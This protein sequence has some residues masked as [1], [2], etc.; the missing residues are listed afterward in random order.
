MELLNWKYCQDNS[1]K[2]LA[3][4]ILTLKDCNSCRPLDISFSDFGNYLISHQDKLFYIGEARD[5]RARAKQQFKRGQNN[6][7]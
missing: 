5:V 6:I 2:I 1:D 3:D 7:N 4:G